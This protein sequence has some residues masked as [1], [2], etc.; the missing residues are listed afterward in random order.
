MERV[1]HHESWQHAGEDQRMNSI[2]QT[3]GEP[4]DGKVAL[5]IRLTESGCYNFI[6]MAEPFKT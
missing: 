4:G 6:C 5:H 1:L 2:Q 3:P